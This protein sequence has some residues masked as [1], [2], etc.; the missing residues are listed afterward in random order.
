[1]KPSEVL[2]PGMI[3]INLKGPIDVMGTIDTLL[4]GDNQSGSSYLQ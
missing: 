1:M 3:G 2:K 4:Q